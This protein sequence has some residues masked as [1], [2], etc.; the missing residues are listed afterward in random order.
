MPYRDQKSALRA[1]TAI[2]TSQGGYFTARQAKKA[3]YDYPHLSYHLSAGNFE[4]A[5]R[6]LYRIPT[7]PYSAHD[8]L[9]RLRFWS[10]G[11]D[12]EPQAVVSHQTALA[13]HDLAEF[14]P[15]RI[16]LT[17]PPSFR[18]P[19][20]KGCMLHKAA[21]A[22]LETQEVESIRVT[23]PFRTLFDLADDPSMPSEQFK[24]A[25]EEASRCGMI[26]RSQADELRSI[27]EAVITTARSVKRRA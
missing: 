26:R 24:L 6:G 27:R 8:D 9:V 3:G 1:I 13:L 19:A 14:I 23:T 15:T 7:L 10:R 22:R 21:L 5:G 16:H 18:K 12:D 11:R 4:R 17:V 20:I 2:A 25:V